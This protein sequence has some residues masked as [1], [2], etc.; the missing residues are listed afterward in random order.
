MI[1]RISVDV[2]IKR[3]GAL[4]R[5]IAEKNIKNK[6]NT[7]DIVQDTFIKILEKK[8]TVDYKDNIKTY[9]CRIAFRTSIDYMRKAYVKHEM[10]ILDSDEDNYIDNNG[11]MDD[12]IKDRNIN[13]RCYYFNAFEENDSYDEIRSSIAQLPLPYSRVIACVYYRDMSIEET[14][15]KLG[16]NKNTVKSRLHRAK[17]LLR[18]EII[19]KGY[20][21]YASC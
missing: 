9:I 18:K 19:N 11:N 17:I 6:Q 3:Y 20:L 21:N 7:D 5:R 1:Q 15:L 13:D 8:E 12:E 14:A 2:L 16:I 4:V 10:L